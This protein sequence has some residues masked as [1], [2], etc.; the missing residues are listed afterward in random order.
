M[1]Y[2]MVLLVSAGVFLLMVAAILGASYGLGVL[3]RTRGGALDASS[4]A[5][6]CARFQADREWYEGLPGWQRSLIT[7]WWLTN[8][9][10]C[11]TQGCG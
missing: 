4:A 9:Y 6:P 10:L 11:S 1:Q 8:R 2:L 5:D 3:L 7:A